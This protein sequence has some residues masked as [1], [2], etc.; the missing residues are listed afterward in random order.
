M[1]RFSKIY[2]LI[3]SIIILGEGCQPNIKDAVISDSQKNVNVTINVPTISPALK[4]KLNEATTA[5]A[6][7]Y[8]TAS[9]MKVILKQNGNVVSTMNSNPN[10]FASNGWGLTASFAA[11]PGSGYTVEVRL[12]NNNNSTTEPVVEGESDP[13]TVTAGES[14]SVSVG[15]L[16]VNPVTLSENTLSNTVD[17]S[18]FNYDMGS[19]FVIS[20]GQE[21]WFKVDAST[22]TSGQV[23][24]ELIPDDPL[25]NGGL[26]AGFSPDVNTGT[27]MV[28]GAPVFAYPDAPLQYTMDLTNS[29][30]KVIYIGALNFNWY[31]GSTLFY[32][33][34]PYKIKW[35]QAENVLA[36]SSGTI[37]FDNVKEGDTLDSSFT[38]QMDSSKIFDGFTLYA[39]AVDQSNPDNWT[40]IISLDNSDWT[41]NPASAYVDFIPSSS[42]PTTVYVHFASAPASTSGSKKYK[43]VFK[44]GYWATQY[45]DVVLNY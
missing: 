41:S 26:I 27:A 28:S 16:P 33:A 22:V 19:D 36:L 23:T 21:A 24:M 7:M 34:G 35:Y 40:T 9:S 42:T 17:L 44:T 25:K 13:F 15:C 20:I 30:S 45:V 6:R 32:E 43:I 1:L 18:P 37:T 31:V 10:Y 12:F 38:V 11:D 5:N 8:L 4:I 3:I 39:Q 14:T 29:S 2:I